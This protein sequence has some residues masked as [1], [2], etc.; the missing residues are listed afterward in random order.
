MDT[1]S[2][3]SLNRF[4]LSS[5]IIL[6]LSLSDS[7]FIE[8]WV[9]W[10]PEQ[11]SLRTPSSPLSALRGPRLQVSSTMPGFYVGT[12]GLD[13]DP[14]VGVLVSILS[15]DK[16]LWQSSAQG[17]RGFFLA[18]SFRLWFI[19]VGKLRHQQLEEAGHEKAGHIASASVEKQGQCMH[20]SAD[21]MFLVSKDA[22]LLPSPLGLS[23][24]QMV[25]PT[26]H[27]SSHHN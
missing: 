15:C 5:L 2:V 7:S 14:Q 13:S 25:L 4:P 18:H 22:P 8:P 19:M 10:S 1:L 16:I 9:H 23:S 17:E 27:R 26:L 6:H 3:T 12:G 21:F 24:Q 20:T 11:R